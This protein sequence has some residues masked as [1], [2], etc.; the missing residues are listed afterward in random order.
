M[1][2]Q[3]ILA[4]QQVDAIEAGLEAWRADSK[5]AGSEL[6]A[7]LAAAVQLTDQVGQWQEDNWKQLLSGDRS[8]DFQAHGSRLAEVYS[9]CLGVCDRLEDRLE[10]ARSVGLVVAG[11]EAFRTARKAFA[12]LDADFRARWPLFTA[13]ELEEGAAQIERGE[14]VTLEEAI[15]ELDAPPRP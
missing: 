2:A 12:A 4:R 11:V 9:L 15:R 13:E 8:F 14:S 5:A 1:I 6:A 7:L 3:A 10:V